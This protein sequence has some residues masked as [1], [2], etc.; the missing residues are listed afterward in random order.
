MRNAVQRR[1]HRERAQPTGRSK[2]GLLEKHSDYALR[3][4]DFA[5]KKKRVKILR[6]KAA[7]RN[8]DEFAFGMM[9]TQTVKGTKVGDRGN[10]ALGQK[11]VELLKTQDAGYLRTMLQVTKKE[12]DRL[13]NEMQLD[14]KN[15]QGAV[16]ALK[17]GA[18]GKHTVFVDDAE[19]QEDFNAEE[20]FGTTPDGLRK[21][22]NRPK[23]AREDAESDKEEIPSRPRSN[24]AMLAREEAAKEARKE[25]RRRL[26]GQD[27]RAQQLERLKAQERDLA[28][29]ELEVELQRARMSN[30]IGGVN[31]NGIKFKIR[32]RKR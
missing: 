28:T 25:E 29:A 15:S 30:S 21:S 31:K 26:K 19:D 12:R 8:P 20:Y 16:K 9:S 24:K 17:G 11:A 14:D 3:A 27:T 13:E 6:Q 7:D 18:Q 32:E 22:F 1:N 4:R 5:D 10:K 23:S 2:W